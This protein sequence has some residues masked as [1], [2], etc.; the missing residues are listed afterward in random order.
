MPF[1]RVLGLYYSP[2]TT[3][4]MNYF[5][6]ALRILLLVGCVTASTAQ[7]TTWKI[8]T[9]EPS[10]PL[11]CLQKID[12]IVLELHVE[13][14][15]PEEV[16]LPNRNPTSVRV[17]GS[18]GKRYVDA[19]EGYYQSNGAKPSLQIRIDY[20]KLDIVGKYEVIFSFNAP[21]KDSRDLTVNL[22]R[23]AAKLESTT[24][25]QVEV[26]AGELKKK[27]S[28]GV[29]ETGHLS[30][31]FD[32]LLTPPL[33]SGGKHTDMIIIP[34][35]KTTFY[36]SK[37]T[38]VEYTINPNTIGDIDYGKYTGKMEVFTT[39]M[40]APL[41]VEFELTNK[42]SKW[43]IIWMIILGV[44][45]GTFVRT[46]VKH[47]KNSSEKKISAYNSLRE[48]MDEMGQI[49]DPEFK[50]DVDK[51]LKKLE[52]AL[53]NPLIPPFGITSDQLDALVKEVVA[54]YTRKRDEFVAKANSLTTTVEKLLPVFEKKDW[55]PSAG[56]F[57]DKLR[58]GF[59]KADA[60]R[61]GL[62]FN[63]TE[64]H[65]AKIEEMV[66]DEWTSLCTMAGDVLSYFESS[67][68]RL[69]LEVKD[70][71]PETE[72]AKKLATAVVRISAEAGKVRQLLTATAAPP[73][74]ATLKAEMAKINDVFEWLMWMGRL[75]VATAAPILS[76]DIGGI[77]D[78]AAEGLSRN[79]KSWADDLLKACS[80]TT[81]ERGIGGKLVS[82]AKM[83]NEAWILFRKLKNGQGV[84]RGAPVDRSTL[85][86]VSNPQTTQIG[87]ESLDLPSFKVK[88]IDA[89]L[90]K[91][92]SNWMIYTF[93]QSLLLIV[94]MALASL[95]VY[96]PTFIGTT[97]ECISIFLFAFTLDVSVEGLLL[98]RDKR[99]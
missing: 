94:F 64:K 96:A 40:A 32:V 77:N 13:D 41:T 29:R 12:T 76:A 34:Q 58:P 14:A 27:D 38:P 7:S 84:Q 91:L 17:A 42:A 61:A 49:K 37:L 39:N 5:R 52:K 48:I 19:I 25:I 8:S 67:E 92:K 54:D 31:V 81:P 57:V 68:G 23:P 80:A 15:K 73:T 63:E 89:Q 83:I 74:L 65:L 69:T 82:D 75:T 85:Q 6:S 46:V 20:S 93:I 3:R 16:T 4:Q 88:E 71:Q 22:E 99:V 70:G 50:A 72:D 62:H 45:S 24:K 28:F 11:R 53:A 51:T 79:F 36:A 26:V 98:L 1:Q 2:P 43:W 55:S 18:L 59:N 97:Y 87:D 44:V 33:F 95:P 86:G 35:P 47:K 66:K 56:A 21:G 9:N 30:G 60:A 78:P 10:I 90:T